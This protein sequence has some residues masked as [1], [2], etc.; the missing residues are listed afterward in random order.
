MMNGLTIT[1]AEIDGVT[2]C[3]PE[4]GTWCERAA[5]HEGPH[6]F[7]VSPKTEGER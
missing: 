5:G 3:I 7:A 1:Y 4:P 6:V 2:V